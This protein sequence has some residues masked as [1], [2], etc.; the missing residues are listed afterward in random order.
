MRFQLK[1]VHVEG[2][3]E[4]AVETYAATRR[5]PMTLAL[6]G[7]PEGMLVS[8]FI[9][10]RATL[11]ALGA[12]AAI[13]YVGAG[14]GLSWWFARAPHNRIHVADVMLPWRWSTLRDLR[15]QMFSAQGVEALRRRDY[16]YGFFLVR[17]GLASHPDDAASRLALAEMLA[18]ARDYEGVRQAVLPQLAFAPVPRPLLAL[19]MT[20]ALRVDDAATVAECGERLAANPASAADHQWLQLRRASALLALR[21]PA[22]ALTALADPA[23]Q[24]SGDAADLKV[25]ALCALERAPEAIALADALPRAHTGEPQRRFRLLARAYRHAGKSAELAGTLKDLIALEPSSVE[26]RLFAI[27][28]LWAGGLRE[29]AQ[30][31]LD[32]LLRR[33]SAQ[34]G[35]IAAIVGRLG[36]DAAPPLIQHCVNEARALGQ[37]VEPMLSTLAMSCVVAADWAGAENAFAALFST[38]RRLTEIEMHARDCLRAT[39]D[40]GATGAAKANA[41]LKTALDVNRLVLPSYLRTAT[42]LALAGRW[43]AAQIVTE[44]ALRYYPRS[45]E[46]QRRAAEAREKAAA[47]AKAAPKPVEAAAP[48]IANR[49]PD[50]SKLNAASF[51]ARLNEHL[52]RKEWDAAADLILAAR[53]TEPAWFGAIAPE[54]DWQEARVA[55][56]REDRLRVTQMIGFGLKQNR[57]EVERALGFA[58]EYR[59]LGNREAELALA[60]KVSEIAPESAVA[61]RYLA[62]LEGK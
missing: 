58:R 44:A 30:R 26:S 25:A 19:L 17:R 51:T 29:E 62:E 36:D 59:A 14:L 33:V 37:P 61:Q 39:I 42:G 15:G 60:R 21:R 50:L 9:K 48:M 52:E 3:H 16:A 7:T 2:R 20:E 38:G 1:F 41:E 23:F 35:A 18:K 34:P 11:L 43:E 12:A 22:D 47:S 28:Q 10:P 5:A 40:A 55:F 54:L 6:S 27:E 24:F 32:A 45:F 13:A 56:G 4:S 53:R 31:E 49:G 8:L 57:R 46:L